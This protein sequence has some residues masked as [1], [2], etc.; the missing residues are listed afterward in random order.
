MSTKQ[1]AIYSETDGS[2]IRSVFCEAALA[3]L[4]ANAGE[5][6]VEDSR[7]FTELQ[8]TYYDVATNQVVD[9]PPKPG[10]WY[11]FNH[12]TKQWVVDNEDADYEA[13]KT[14]QLLLQQSD[15]TD[16]ASAPD[17]LGQTLYDQWQTY[18]QALRDIT[19]QTGYPFIIWPVPPS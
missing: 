15:W 12:Q 18:R 8:N 19:K 16:T 9:M 3:S 6:A 2:F 14:R 11:R 17:R 10:Q 5:I 13:K 4:Q 1:L 7:K